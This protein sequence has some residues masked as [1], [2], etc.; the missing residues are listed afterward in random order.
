MEQVSRRHFIKTAG[1]AGISIWLGLSAKGA[2][3]KTSDIAAAKN[4]SPY[5]LVE[6]NGN[7]TIYNI[8]PEMGQG[9]FQSVPAVIAEEFEVSLDQVK[10]KNTSGEPEFGRGQRA[11]GSSSIRTGYNDYRK[12]G[13]AARTVFIVAAAK[14]WQTSPDNCYAR[15]A[16]VIN[17]TNDQSFTYGELVEDA[18]RLDLPKDPKLKDPKDFTIVGKMSHR[19]DIPLKT[20]GEAKFGIDVRVPG[21]VYASVE[22]CPVIGG[23]LKNFDA[24]DALKIAGVL[25]VVE[26]ERVVGNYRY[27]GVAVIADSYWT[28]LQARKKLK[29][30]WDY[31]GFDNFDSED[32][33][34]HLRKLADEEG[35]V[36]KN[37][38]NADKVNVSLQNTVDAFYETPV[39]AHSP[40]EPMNAVAQVH[41]DNLEIW[42][43]T[44]VPSSVV[45]SSPNE[46]PKLTGFSP[47]NVKM[48]NMFVGGG[49]GRRLYLD[50]LVEA[51]NIAKQYDKPVKVIWSRED[52]TQ[53]GP[54][55]PMTFS[56]LSGGFSDDGKLLVLKHK[57]ISPSIS[58]SARP[59]FDKTKVDGT[60]VEGIGEQDYQVPNIKTS[61]VRADYHVPVAAWRSVTSSTLAFA[62]ECFMDELAHKA[63]KDPLD[64]RMSLLAPDS[65]TAKIFKK[66]REVS[67]WDQPLPK[68]SGRG[69]AQ[70]K[71][72]AGQC[73]QA[74]EV[75]LRP[76]GT[77]KV[78]KVYAVIDLGVAVNPDNVRNQTEGA[79]VMALTAATKPAI[80]LKNGKVMQ[81]NFYD[82]TM[83]RI[84]EVPQVEVHIL[85]GEGKIKGVGEPG[86]PPF[87]PALANAIFAATGTRIRKMPFDL[88]IS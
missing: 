10:I 27:T 65:D 59:N 15:N 83:I 50:Y 74:V 42:T 81:H 85:T 1:T 6:S 44:Q 49:F 32:Y 22:R 48:H 46:L 33:D 21:M 39:V 71:F 68:G 56:K 13:A 58:E 40:M 75:T 12:T 9:T 25:K 87:A 84:N 29:I 41:G 54:F 2:I 31:K 73:A 57:V 35:L 69:L 77:I 4:F 72:F 19:P 51:V 30:N 37:I 14:R 88:K 78:D 86:L 64:F 8:K 79:V 17:R 67:N 53:F 76:D 3:I 63:G 18:A 36:D 43:S 80:T 70:W 47:E 82:N 38:G 5:I 34:E 11:G 26:A 23:V 60:M 28:A 24:S 61:Y 20:C 16:K 55:R 62:H 52:T 45:G 66:L 7:I